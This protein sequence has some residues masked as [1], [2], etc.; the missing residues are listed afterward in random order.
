MGSL[1]RSLKDTNP[2]LI[3]DKAF[4]VSSL[5]QSL[6]FLAT[7]E[8]VMKIYVKYID[9]MKI[10]LNSIIPKYIQGMHSNSTVIYLPDKLVCL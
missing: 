8:D 3:H 4:H 10:A 5:F 7:T 6:F 1:H 9:V 2:V